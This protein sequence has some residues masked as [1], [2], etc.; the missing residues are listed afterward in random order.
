MVITLLGHSGCG[1]SHLARR[2]A[3]ERSF[4][5]MCCDDIIEKKLAEELNTL[6]L[7]SIKGVSEWMGQPYDSY[8]EERQAKYLACE[9]RVMEEIISFLGEDGWGLNEDVVVDTSGSVIYTGEEILADL[10]KRSRII[11]LRVPESEYEF[12]FNQYLSD[13][14]PVIWNGLFNMEAKE[15]PSDALSRCYPDL[16]KARSHLYEEFADVV[17]V[18]DRHNRDRFSVRRLLHLAGAR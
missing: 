8:S 2:L 9:C 15:S 7:S 6:G 4:R 11:Y 18:I 5:N 17:F 14:K 3:E 10:K 16:I 1:K 12:M 13:P